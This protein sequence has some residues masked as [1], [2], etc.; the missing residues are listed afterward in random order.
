MAPRRCAG[1]TTRRWPRSPA[2]ERY[3]FIGIQNKLIA[4]TPATRMVV[5]AWAAMVEQLVL[6]WVEDPTTM[7]RD[8]LLTTVTGSLPALV[9]LP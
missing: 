2:G 3:A 9:S 4:D 7:T 8:Q 5:R 1:S 6:G